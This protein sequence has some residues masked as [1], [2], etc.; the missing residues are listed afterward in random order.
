V[1]D[2]L[3]AHPVVHFACHAVS[4]WGSPGRSG[5]LLSDRDGGGS[6]TARLTVDA[7]SS[8]H[9]AGAELAYLSA[10]S[11]SLTN[12]RLA[13]ESVHIT[14]G[15]MLCGYRHVIGTLWPVDD[16]VAGEIA[17]DFYTRLAGDDGAGLRTESAAH[18]LHLG[19]H[20]GRAKRPWAPSLWAAHLHTGA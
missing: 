8:R 19:L 3:P 18:A 15:F 17:V 13:D 14:A 1:L 10:C 2:A 5:L 16:T 9:I 6:G 12:Q 11:T 4:E 7:I 20:Q